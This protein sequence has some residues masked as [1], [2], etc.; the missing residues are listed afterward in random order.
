MSLPEHLKGEKQIFK[1]SRIDLYVVQQTAQDGGKHQREI[2]IHPGAVVVLP[3]LNA[4]EIIF[5]RNYRI[6]VN[7]VLLELP[8]GTLEPQELPLETAKRELVE[9]TGYECSEIEFLTKFYT[10]PGFSNELMHVFFAKDLHYLGQKL[11][12]SEEI[13]IEIITFSKALELIQNG[14]I[15]DAKTIAAFFYY[16]NF[17]LKKN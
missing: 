15:C 4:D 8:A 14:T 12:P 11:D 6:A 7:K 3:L 16:Y 13:E 2:V 10:T 17:K 9:E 5:I 1:G